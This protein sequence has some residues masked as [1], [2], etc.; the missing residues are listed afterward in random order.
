MPWIT[1]KA[2]DGEAPDGLGFGEEVE[3]EQEA[4]KEGPFAPFR[5]MDEWNVDSR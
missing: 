3:G 4:A 5:V 1:P 2:E